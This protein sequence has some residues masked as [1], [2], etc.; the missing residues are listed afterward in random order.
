MVN[1]LRTAFKRHVLFQDV[2]CCRDYAETV[3]ASFAHQIKPECYGGSRSVSIEG[4]LLEH[5]SA[6]PHTEMNL[7]TKSCL[8]YAVFHYLVVE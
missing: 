8:Q 5:F 3:V 4:T 2:F 6:L 1:L 7:S